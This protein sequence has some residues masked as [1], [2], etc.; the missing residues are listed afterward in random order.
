MNP[1]FTNDR[2]TATDKDTSTGYL[3][4][5]G[6]N[7]LARPIQNVGRL[8][9]DLSLGYGTGYEI[10]TRTSSSSTL[11]ASSS[12]STA[13]LDIEIKEGLHIGAIIGL[14]F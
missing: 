9:A 8:Y 14:M 7:I 4:T 2:P 13:D 10:S 5:L 1:L 12:N 11:S 3:A 6:L